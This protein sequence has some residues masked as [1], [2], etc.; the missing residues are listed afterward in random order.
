MEL[1]MEKGMGMRSGS[2][3]QPLCKVLGM[4]LDN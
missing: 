2:E 1:M 4:K 3:G